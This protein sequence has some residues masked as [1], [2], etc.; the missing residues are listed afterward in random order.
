MIQS[1]H[2]GRG[3]RGVLNYVMNPEKEPELVAGNMYGTDPR[4]L[5]AEFKQWRELRPGLGKAVFHSSL[6]LPHGPGGR[7]ELSDAQWRDVAER[8]LEHLG[9]GRSPFVV[10]RHRD[11]EHDHV[12]I[13]A[14]RIDAEGRAVSD[15]NDYRRGEKILRQL[16]REYGL[17]PV[18]SSR[19]VERSA[20]TV[21]EMR[22]LERSGGVS[23]RLRLQD[24]LD[25][26]AADGPT[27]SQF[28]ARL[29][30][31]GVEVVPRVAKTGHVSGISYR[32]DGVAFRGSALGRAYSWLGIQQ[33]LG[34]DYRPERDLSAVRRATERTDLD[35]TPGETSKLWSR[36]SLE[37]LQKELRGLGSRNGR[38]VVSRE[39]VEG[40]ARRGQEALAGSASAARLAYAFRSR[41]GATRYVARRLP[42]ARAVVPLLD[43]TRAVRSPL[44]LLLY[45]SRLATSAGRLAAGS[46]KERSVSPET[47]RVAAGFIRAAAADRPSMPSFLQRLRAAGV[48]PLPLVDRRDRVRALAYQVGDEL[49]AGQDLGPAFTWRG[50][51]N[52]LGVT[53]EPQRDL[54]RIRPGRERPGSRDPARDREPARGREGAVPGD[55]ASRDP[56]GH[57]E[58]G[59][60]THER[61]AGKPPASA[62]RD[63]EDAGTPPGRRPGRAPAPNEPPTR[64]GAPGEATRPAGAREANAPAPR[65]DGGSRAR[66]GA[67]FPVGD[68]G[69]LADDRLSDAALRSALQRSGVPPLRTFQ[70]R[71]LY[72]GSLD[73]AD[74]AWATAALRGGVQPHLVLR[75]VA[76]RG[77]RSSASPEAR[78]THGTRVLARALATVKPAR[79]VE[80]TVSLAAQ[81]LAVVIKAPIAVVKALLIIRS[82]ARELSQERGR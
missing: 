4:A 80:K 11:T 15:S 1:I 45:G 33:R 26:A 55:P 24:L 70:E 35:R 19:E 20:M 39:A 73:R 21:G 78:V 59:G 17:E 56:R 72:V 7:E 38:G 82:I 52:R 57:R 36:K 30:G 71:K 18:R 41:Q 29:E 74:A 16:E 14:A 10:V 23:T 25:R 67:G 75:E 5:A 61:R 22:H 60:A 63:L 13:V 69:H 65:H 28:L 12:H 76:L 68:L 54:P 64:L 50:V 51:Q 27:M 53:Y 79:S 43:L 49:V 48:E 31:A 81:A 2:K 42:G 9:Y 47:R 34:V 3:F 44:G 40:L 37:A 6:S 62:A 77:G 58:A 66:A 32:L 46:P 8:Y